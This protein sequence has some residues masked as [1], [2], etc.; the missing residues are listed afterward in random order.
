MRYS[1]LQAGPNTHAGGAK[2]GCF[3]LAY[4]EAESFIGIASIVAR[5]SGV[6]LASSELLRNPAAQM[7]A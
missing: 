5:S 6:L 4:Q 7:G 3:R 1:T 2:N